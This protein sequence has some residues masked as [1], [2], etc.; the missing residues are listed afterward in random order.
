MQSQVRL[1]SFSGKTPRP[2]QETDYETSRTQI[3]LLQ[4]DPNM[5]PLQISRKI[6]ES[7][8][9]PATDVVKGLQPESPPAAYLQLLDSAFGSVEDGE[10][11]FAQFLNTFQDP[12]EKS[13]IYLHQLQLALNRATKGGGVT[14]EE[15]NK[16]LIKQFCRGCWDNTLLSVLQLEQ[17]RSSP[18]KFS[19]LLLMIRS[20]ED[21]WQ[22]ISSRMKKHIGIAKQR[23]QVQ[24]Q[25]AY[26]CVPEE[27]NESSTS[28]I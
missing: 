15:V 18:P 21:R 22:T 14:R 10:E 20:E 5:T 4:N 17:K 13:S 6:H 3:E 23:A 2:N 24:F 25:G 9:P 1:R 27:K 11:L 19:D 26:G 28:E 7:L 8:L 16:H 12:C